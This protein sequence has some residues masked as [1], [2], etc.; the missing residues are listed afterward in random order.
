MKKIQMVGHVSL[1]HKKIKENY[2][3]LLKMR[4]ISHDGKLPQ[5]LFLEEQSI[6]KFAQKSYQVSKKL[7]KENEKRPVFLDDISI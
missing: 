4:Q 3:M 1:L 2:E 7:D 6:I 5:G